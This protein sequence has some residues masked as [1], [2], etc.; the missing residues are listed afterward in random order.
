[1][2][3]ANFYRRFL[4]ESSLE[5]A[6]FGTRTLSE[7]C[8]LR[9]FWRENGGGVKLFDRSYRGSRS[10]TSEAE[11]QPICVVSGSYLGGYLVVVKTCGI[12]M[13]RNV[14]R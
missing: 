10:S 9:T 5:G 4:V 8:P 11:N 2:F 6:A 1:M 7:S 3:F 12:I 13:V 14:P